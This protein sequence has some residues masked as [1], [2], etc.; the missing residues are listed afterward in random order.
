MVVMEVF[1]LDHRKILDPRNW[2]DNRILDLKDLIKSYAL[3]KLLDCGIG[4]RIELKVEFV[5]SQKAFDAF[6]PV[7]HIIGLD[8]VSKSKHQLI[9]TLGVLVRAW[10]DLLGAPL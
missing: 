9:I 8:I 7:V 3:V 6:N 1:N 5:V 4:V 2:L 10:L